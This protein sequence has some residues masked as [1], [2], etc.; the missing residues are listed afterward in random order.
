EAQELVSLLSGLSARERMILR[1]HYSLDGEPEQ[2]LSEIAQRLGLST[3]RVRDIE[4]RARG[5]LAAA[6]RTAGA[7]A[8]AQAD[9]VGGD[10]H[11]Q[12]PRRTL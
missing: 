11:G 7:D 1:A 4:R 8:D 12:E 10:G 2:S 9:A 3:A 5:K 6:A